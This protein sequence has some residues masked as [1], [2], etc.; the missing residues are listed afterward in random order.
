MK[1]HQNWFHFE[2]KYVTDNIEGTS[3]MIR[4][5]WASS[6]YL[7]DFDMDAALGKICNKWRLDYSFQKMLA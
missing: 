1:L 4:I 5:L 7:I 6:E 2:P 3:C